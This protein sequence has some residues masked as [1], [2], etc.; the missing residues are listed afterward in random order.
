[1][2]GT[3]IALV[4]AVLIAGAPTSVAAEQTT[5]TSGP[6]VIDGPIDPKTANWRRLPTG[7]ELA[8]VYPQKAMEYGKSGKAVMRCK[9]TPTGDLA[10]C[11]VISEAP[12]DYGFGGA[13]LELAPY[14]HLRAAPFGPNA[15]IEIPVSFDVYP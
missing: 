12:A 10:N 11:L 5:Q 8:R 2:A 9:V 13:A 3:A 14:F 1:M 7:E 15:S 6:S 4:S